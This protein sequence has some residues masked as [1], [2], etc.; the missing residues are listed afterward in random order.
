MWSSFFPLTFLEQFLRVIWEAVSQAT[1]L[2][3]VQSLSRVQLF[4]IPWIAARQASLSITNSQSS[5]KLM[6]IE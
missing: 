3:S 5:L 1:V 4:V 2:S 6:T